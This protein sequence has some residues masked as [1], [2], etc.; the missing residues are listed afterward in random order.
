MD[1]EEKKRRQ[2]IRIVIAEVGM[3]LSVIAIVVVATLAAMGF[4]ISGNGGIEQYGLMQLHSL[5]TGAA[6][7]I[8]ENTLFAR[9]NL[10]RTLASGQHQLEISRDGY[11]TWSKTITIYPGVLIRIYYPRLF[12]QNRVV[13]EVLTLMEK[14]NLE[15]YTP[16]AS[17][18]YIIY[19][20]RG[21]SEWRM[22]DIRGDEV[23]TTILDLSGV[24]P[25]MVEEK[26]TSGTVTAKD[27]A[28]IAVTHNYKF[29][30]KIEEVRWSGNEESV[31]VKVKYE[32]KSSWVLVRLR[33]MAKSVNLTETF[34]LSSD[35]R[36]EFIDDAASQLFALEQRQLRR[37]N[38]SDGVM[39]RILVGNVVDFSSRGNSTVYVTENPTTK[40]REIGVFRDDDKSGTTITEVPNAAKAQ[41]ALSSYYGDD[42]I[43]YAIDSEVTILYGRL[44]SYHENASGLGELKRLTDG[45]LALSKTPTR[46]SVSPEGEYVVGQT[47]DSLMVIDLD[48]GDLYEYTTPSAKLRWFDSSMLYD[49]KDGQILV[50]DFDGTNQRNLAKSA[51]TAG[52]QEVAVNDAPIVVTANNRYLYYLSFDTDKGLVLARE[53]IRE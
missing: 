13:E 46:L 21:S 14:N 45:T 23:K 53:K 3:V 7:T 6:V 4:M 41:V 33:D 49:I 17:R 37:I 27:N 31:L 22:L 52:G 48:M 28:A 35:V 25:G 40:I 32:E 10:S 5:P 18:N 12:L 2:R 47:G 24:L 39:S 43:V 19:A 34:G 50:W 1:F 20:E 42:Y 15:F 8:D 26:V 16:S 30:G 38:A 29:E 51:T 11:D 44:P 9:T 36:L